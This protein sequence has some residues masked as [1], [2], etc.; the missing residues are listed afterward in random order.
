MRTKQ[1]RV[2]GNAQVMLFFGD[3]TGN[4]APVTGVRVLLLPTEIIEDI[5]IIG[6]FLQ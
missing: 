5:E 1:Q 2:C 3:P 4:R 6:L